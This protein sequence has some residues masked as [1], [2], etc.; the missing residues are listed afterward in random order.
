MA[1]GMTN[2]QLLEAARARNASLTS[3]NVPVGN[4]VRDPYLRYEQE[5]AT[6]AAIAGQ[7]RE[8]EGDWR[9]EMRGRAEEAEASSAQQMSGLRAGLVKSALQGG[10]E[11]AGAGAGTSRGQYRQTGIEQA[12]V[13]KRLGKVEGR[14]AGL[15]GEPGGNI[16]KRG[17]SGGALES[18]LTRRA[19]VLGS[20]K[21]QLGRQLESME[22]WYGYDPEM[23]TQ[24]ALYGRLTGGSPTSSDL[25]G[26]PS[27]PAGTVPGVAPKVPTNGKWGG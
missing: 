14:I 21:K 13:G 2:E 19:D 22:E 27:S 18:R 10:L 3:A 4:D 6:N 9:R 11:A 16:Y 17:A 15:S 7:R 26:Q 20:R 12:Q 25:L 8:V 5:R 1:Y 23:Y 24:G